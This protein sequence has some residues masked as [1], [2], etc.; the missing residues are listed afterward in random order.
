MISAR[1]APSR[2][3]SRSECS[4]VE[5]RQVRI[6]PSAVNR[7]REQA[8]QKASVTGAMMPISPGAPSAKRKREAVSEPR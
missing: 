8:P 4:T 5:K 7:M 3:T 6:W 1:E 2:T